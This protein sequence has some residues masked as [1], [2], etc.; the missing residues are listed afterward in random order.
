MKAQ[1]SYMEKSQMPMVLT[2]ATQILFA[3]LHLW[4]HEQVSRSVDRRRRHEID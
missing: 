1:V 4:L 2:L 3:S